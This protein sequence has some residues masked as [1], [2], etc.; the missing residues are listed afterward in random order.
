MGRVVRRTFG[1]LESERL[2]SR[3]WTLNLFVEVRVDGFE[4][5]VVVVVGV[6]LEGSLRFPRGGFVLFR[7]HS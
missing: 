4:L 1:R 3:C 6:V 2:D 7:R 5:L